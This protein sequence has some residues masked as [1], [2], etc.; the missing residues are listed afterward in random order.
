MINA[1]SILAGKPEGKRPLGSP[2]HRQ[3][4]NTK[5]VLNKTEWE[6]VGAAFVC[7]RAGTGGG[8]L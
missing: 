4:D 7:I 6:S 2:R 8:I 5:M 3:D 1:Q